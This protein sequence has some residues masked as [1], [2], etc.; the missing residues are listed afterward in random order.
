MIN[1]SGTMYSWCEST[2]NGGFLN[3]PLPSGDVS[4]YTP[5]EVNGGA[6]WKQVKA[7]PGGLIIAAIKTNGTLWTWSTLAQ[8]VN[9]IPANATATQIGTAT[10]WVD[11]IV[12]T[13]YV[14]GFKGASTWYATAFGIRGSNGKGDLY[15]WGDTTVGAAAGSGASS[16]LLMSCCKAVCEREVE[17]NIGDGAREEKTE[18]SNNAKAK[19]ALHRDD[20]TLICISVNID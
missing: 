14:E 12:K 1:S 11:A 15:A 4:E 6:V 3:R 18:A 19:A 7:Y 13:Y 10:D 17:N 16:S 20:T 8:T 5:G 2:Q 9:N